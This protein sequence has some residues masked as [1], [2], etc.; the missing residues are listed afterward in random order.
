[1]KMDELQ[2]HVASKP[3]RVGRISTSPPA[4]AITCANGAIISVQ[5]SEYHYCSPNSD[6]GPWT[7]FEI[8]LQGGIHEGALALLKLKNYESAADELGPYGWV[9]AEDVLAIINMNGGRD[10]R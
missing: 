2:A 6:E 9:A 1:M 4:P 8:M 10:V 5:G 3:K 7:S